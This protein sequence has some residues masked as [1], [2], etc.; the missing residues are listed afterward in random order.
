VIDAP[1][2][3]DPMPDARGEAPEVGRPPWVVR[4]DG[5]D[6]RR[7]G[8]PA[9]MQVGLERYEPVPP[10]RVDGRVERLAR[11]AVVEHDVGGRAAGR[12][13]DLCVDPGARVVGGHP[14]LQHQPLHAHVAVG[15]D[16]DHEVVRRCQAALDEQ[17]YVVDDDR[18]GGCLRDPARGGRPYERMDDL[19]EPAPRLAVAEH[20][21]AQRRPVEA[22]VGA[23]DLLAEGRDHLRQPVRAGLDDLP[24]EH[25]GVDDDR[26]VGGESRGSRALAGADAAGQTHHQ[27]GSQSTTACTA[28]GPARCPGRGLP[29]CRVR[30]TCRRRASRAG[31]RAPRP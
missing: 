7:G 28:E 21:P 16:H 11:A 10:Q 14:P 30:P 6:R 2:G 22:A 4:D 24:R 5:R 18:V 27:H 17:G 15:V 19:L 26:P 20:D 1:V 9:R 31:R 23:E 13:V 8:R 25:V 29:W 3:A 12:V